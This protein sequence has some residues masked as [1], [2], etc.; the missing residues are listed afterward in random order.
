MT[1]EEK[2]NYIKAQFSNYISGIESLAEFKTFLNNITKAKIIT[3]LKN[4]VQEEIDTRTNYITDKGT[5]V[6]ELT[7]FKNQIESFL[8]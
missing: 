3:A 6:T 7:E 8:E 1:D 2:L 4:K 5:I